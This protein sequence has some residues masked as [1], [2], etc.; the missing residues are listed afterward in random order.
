LNPWGRKSTW[1]Q[2]MKRGDVAVFFLFIKKR[3]AIPFTY[4]IALLAWGVAGQLLF[5]P[6]LFTS[7]RR[8]QVLGVIW[9]AIISRA[10][11]SPPN[12]S[13]NCESSWV[14][15]IIGPLRRAGGHALW[16]GHDRA[17]AGRITTHLI[18]FRNAAHRGNSTSSSGSR[19]SPGRQVFD[20]E[21]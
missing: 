18:S 14:R 21:S 6:T 12:I 13:E 10:I 7:R 5:S 17:R 4:P 2:R 15:R 16:S 3:M 20:R 19:F 8:S 11:Y 1:Q 9:G